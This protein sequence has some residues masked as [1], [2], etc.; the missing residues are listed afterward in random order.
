M[1]TARQEIG[2]RMLYAVDELVEGLNKK[3]DKQNTK[4]FWEAFAKF[5]PEYL[6]GKFSMVENN[7]TGSIVITYKPE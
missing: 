1:A 6:V 5:G 4:K 2:D 7:D 3:A